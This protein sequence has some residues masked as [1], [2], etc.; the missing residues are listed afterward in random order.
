M[1]TTIK[2]VLEGGGFDLSKPEDAQ[3]LLSKR[4]EF[5]ELVE[6]AEELIDLG[7]E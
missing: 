3:W 4:S 5:D 2:E 7:E 1:S 6:Q